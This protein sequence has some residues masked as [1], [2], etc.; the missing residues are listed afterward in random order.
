MTA[1]IDQPAIVVLAVD[2]DQMPRQFAEQRR[3]GG[4]VVDE[5]FRCNSL[6]ARRPTCGR[7][8]LPPQDERFA[9]FYLDPRLI[10]RLDQ[11]GRQCGK[12][13]AGGHARPVAARA[14]QPGLGAVAQHQPK[15][16][17][18]DR[19][20]RPGL[21]GQHPQPASKRQ[22]ERLDQD[23]VADGELGQHGRRSF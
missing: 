14:Q 11:R 1:R 21:A 4:L 16:V 5:A 9:R 18:Q 23:D 7:F 3:P 8:Q 22:V 6:V 10:Q 17:E 12:F 20:A 2:L 19:F 13:K 15:R